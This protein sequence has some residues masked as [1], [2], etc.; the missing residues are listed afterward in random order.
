[1]YGCTASG[2]LRAPHREGEPRNTANRQQVGKLIQAK[3][4]SIQEH[5][6]PMGAQE[7]L[8][9]VTSDIQDIQMQA[10]QIPQ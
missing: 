6:V 1:M 9:Q 3:F 5:L 8:I 10:Q 7:D 2:L 4:G